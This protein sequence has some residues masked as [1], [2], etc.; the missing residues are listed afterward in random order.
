MHIHISCSDGEAKFWLE[1]T[2]AL[3]EYHGLSAI[4]LNELQKIV[5]GKKDEIIRS[6]KKHFKS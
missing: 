2:I 1:P 5:M 3:S 4:K 6:W